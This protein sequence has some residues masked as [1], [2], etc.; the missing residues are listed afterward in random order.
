[1]GDL[2][3]VYDF[4]NDAAVLHLFAARR[5]PVEHAGQRALP[6]VDVAGGHEV[7]EGAEAGV[8]GD[9]LEGARQPQPGDAVGGRARQV[10]VAAEEDTAVLWP[11]E[12]ADAIED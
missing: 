2:Q 7:V 12:A 11:V 8:E 4:F 10:G 5:P 1:M 6:H 9:I 3:E